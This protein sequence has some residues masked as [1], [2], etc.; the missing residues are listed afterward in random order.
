MLLGGGQTLLS[1]DKRVDKYD[2]QL[3]FFIRYPYKKYPKKGGRCY[4]LTYFGS[5]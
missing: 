4:F 5:T 1:G 2:E 3:Y